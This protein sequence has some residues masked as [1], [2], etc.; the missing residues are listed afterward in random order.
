MKKLLA[1]KAFFAPKRVSEAVNR[2][3]IGRGV[4]ALHLRKIEV[5]KRRQEKELDRQIVSYIS[6]QSLKTNG[7]SDRDQYNTLTCCGQQR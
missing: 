6:T 3:T 2:I 1:E 5:G 7:L 4:W